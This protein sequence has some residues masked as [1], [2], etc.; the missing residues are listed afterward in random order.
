MLHELVAGHAQTLLAELRDADP[1]GGGLARCVERE[2]A[3]YLRCGILSVATRHVD[4]Y[5]PQECRAH[6][7]VIHRDLARHRGCN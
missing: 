5:S 2:L 4:V 3:A 1:E 6:N 7:A